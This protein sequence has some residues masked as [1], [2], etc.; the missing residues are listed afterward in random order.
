MVVGGREA[1]VPH[2]V[3][4]GGMVWRHCRHDWILL[5]KRR[6]GYVVWAIVASGSGDS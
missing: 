4:S 5:D 1:S 3:R 2:V 6:V